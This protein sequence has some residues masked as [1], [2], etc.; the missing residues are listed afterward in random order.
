[1]WEGVRNISFRSEFRNILGWYR[2]H[3]G[4]SGKRWNSSLIHGISL[5]NTT[6]ASSWFSSTYTAQQPNKSLFWFYRNLIDSSFLTT[7]FQ[8]CILYS[9]N[10]DMIVNGELWRIE[11]IVICFNEMSRIY[12]ISVLKTTEVLRQDNRSLWRDL[13]PRFPEC[14]AGI[15]TTN[16]RWFYPFLVILGLRSFWSCLVFGYF[17]LRECLMSETVEALWTT[18]HASEESSRCTW[19]LKSEVCFRRLRRR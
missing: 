5:H 13:N 15:L 12:S 3:G 11:A 17:S 19:R 6:P 4:E 7:Y 18:D 9:V 1:M 16:P 14:G 8:L 10:C 2:E